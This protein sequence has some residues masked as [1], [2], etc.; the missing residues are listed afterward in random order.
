LGWLASVF[1]AG[2]RGKKAVL[3]SRSL[4]RIKGYLL[5]NKAIKYEIT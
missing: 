3:F 2:S 4:R 1:I 5:T